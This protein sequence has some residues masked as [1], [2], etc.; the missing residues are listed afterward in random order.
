MARRRPL[1]FTPLSTTLFTNGATVNHSDAHFSQ[2]G[3]PIALFRAR[4]NRGARTLLA[5]EVE[6]SPG[7]ADDSVGQKVAQGGFEDVALDLCGGDLGM[8]RR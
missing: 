3:L 2:V 1:P 7:G 4:R 5:G 6:A 8:R